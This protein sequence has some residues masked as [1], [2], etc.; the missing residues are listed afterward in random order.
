MPIRDSVLALLVTVIWG[1]NFVVIDEGL[2]GM[3]PVLFVAI[4]FV[5]VVFPAI[6]F[7][8]RPEVPWRVLGTV[9]L[10][11]SIGQFGLLYSALKV[12]M[13]A[14]LA[15]LVLQ[16]QVLLT[17]LL[18]AL[19]LHER[20]TTRQLVGVGLGIVG[21]AVVA[22]GRSAATPW[23]GL[24]LTLA[25]ALSWATGNIAARQARVASGL[26]LTVWSAL[27]VPVP[28]FLLSLALDGPTAVGHALGHLSTAN[29]L[30][31]LYTA[32]LA[33][34][35]GYGIW[36]TLLARHAA[37]QV[38]PFTLLVPVTGMLT[39]WLVQQERPGPL[40]L[41]GGVV[42]LLGVAVTAVGGWRGERKAEPLPM[43]PLTEGRAR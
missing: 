4:R 42:L 26:S 2:D 34:L 35:V 40:E 9:G 7:V 14:G 5:V 24:L 17:V 29:V 25:A 41:T 30:S 13:P 19:R 43:E 23:L 37:A 11:L 18:A 36:N 10:F 38:V 39:A 31:T 6:L 21:L 33:S 16:A 27:F 20:P 12:G 3:P 15:S 8:K 32:V 28:M 1:A 22:G